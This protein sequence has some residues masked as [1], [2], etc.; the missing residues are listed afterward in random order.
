M[1]P[2]CLVLV[3]VH[4]HNLLTNEHECEEDFVDGN[5]LKNLLTKL[6]E[7]EGQVRSLGQGI[8]ES[9]PAKKVVCPACSPKQRGAWE[10]TLWRLEQWLQH[11]EGTLKETMKRR[12]P[13]NLE[14]LEDQILNHRVNKQ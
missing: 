2:A 9:S 5:K 11:A 7:Q 4:L 14:Q 12:P 1:G 3:L 10:S 13:S 6:R 8:R